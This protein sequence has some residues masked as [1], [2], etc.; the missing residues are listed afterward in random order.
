MVILL[1]FA[2]YK[3]KLK[4]KPIVTIS[5]RSGNQPHQS[6]ASKATVTKTN[7]RD[8]FLSSMKYVERLV[9]RRARYA[10]CVTLRPKPS[11]LK[12]EQLKFW[13]KCGG[14]PGKGLK[15]KDE[16]VKR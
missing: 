1:F 5:I 4:T 11:E 12:N 14:D 13:L 16:L 9:S 15:T 10:C 2:T 3:R 7:R 8:T 6:E